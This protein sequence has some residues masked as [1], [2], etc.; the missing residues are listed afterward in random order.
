M[1][2]PARSQAAPAPAPTARQQFRARAIAAIAATAL[3]TAA[4]A[5]GRATAPDPESS[6]ES[7]D[8]IHQAYTDFMTE[9]ERQLHWSQSRTSSD[10]EGQAQQA[11]TAAISALNLVQQNP[12]CVSPADRAAAQTYLDELAP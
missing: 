1:E 7:C 9:S 10:P 3:A 8:E 12:D 5:A 6:A 11:R 2:D 4:F